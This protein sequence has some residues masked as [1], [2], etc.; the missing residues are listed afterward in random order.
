[1]RLGATHGGPSRC[2]SMEPEHPPQPISATAARQGQKMNVGRWV[3]IFGLLLVIP[4][5]GLIW[6]LTRY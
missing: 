1:M 6:Y 3:L 5:M 4:G 2:I